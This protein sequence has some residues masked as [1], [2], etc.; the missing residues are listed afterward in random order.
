[1]SRRT[2]GSGFNNQIYEEACEWFVDM[3]DGD[4]DAAGKQRFDAWVRKSPEHLR[5]YLEISEIWDDASL[6]DPARKSSAEKL[7]VRAQDVGAHVIRL[8]GVVGGGSSVPARPRSM[9]RTRIQLAAAAAI[10]FMAVGLGVFAGYKNLREPTYSTGIGEQ[11]SVVL[12]DG[13]RVQLNSRTRLQVRFTEH[14]RNIELLE[15]QAL[16]N[17]AKNPQTT[18]RRE[19]RRSLRARCRHRVRRRSQAKCHDS[20]R[21]RG[22]GRCK[23]ARRS[24]GEN[25][26]IDAD[27]RASPASL[28]R[29]R[30]ASKDEPA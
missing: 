25:H 13:S 12:A 8:D 27:R 29:C 18:L 19:E 24:A 11:R 2:A 22:A 4:V 28:R 6:V 20:H 16:F 3:R 7:I 15:G 21:A 5:A 14:D 9:S 10:A 17:V 1:M 30:R 23:L 26:R